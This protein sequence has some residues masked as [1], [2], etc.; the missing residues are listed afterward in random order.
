VSTGNLIRSF[1]VFSHHGDV[2]A[3]ERINAAASQL[4]ERIA[5]AR[6]NA[7][8]SGVELG[9]TVERILGLNPGQF[10]GRISRAE[11]GQ[12]LGARYVAAIAEATG[13]R[14]EWLMFGSGPRVDSERVERGIA[15]LG[16][17]DDARV[18]VALGE[19]DLASASPGAIERLL[20]EL[21][22][23]RQTVGELLEL[24]A[25]RQKRAP[26]PPPDRRRRAH[27]RGG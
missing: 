23:F 6:K 26:K 24:D 27:R 16:D 19:S 22:H 18:L 1:A 5:W 12:E 13:V 25:L 17:D 21:A 4:G 7:S 14:A 2:V 9:E 10:G 20:A 8:M 11:A 15:A 3:A